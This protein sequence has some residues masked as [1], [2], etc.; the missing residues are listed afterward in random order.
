VTDAVL[1]SSITDGTLLVIDAGRTRRGA[2]RH[3]REALDKAGARILGVTLNRVSERSSG[4]Y[5]Y[6]YYGA[7]GAEYDG[8]PDVAREATL[9]DKGR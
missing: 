9:A 3:G 1:L 2:V 7:Y 6:D 8:Q 5:Y 4:G